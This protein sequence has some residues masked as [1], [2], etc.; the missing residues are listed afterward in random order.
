MEYP[1]VFATGLH[2]TSSSLFCATQW[3][4]SNGASVYICTCEVVEYSPSVNVTTAYKDLGHNEHP[5]TTA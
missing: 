3:M 1:F 5:F 4:Y 2:S